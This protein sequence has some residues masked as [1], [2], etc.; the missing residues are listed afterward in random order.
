VSV[1]EGLSPPYAT[2]VADPPWPVEL[3]YGKRKGCP[4]PTRATYSTMPV[5]AICA[6]PVTELAA[7]DAH[8]YLWVTPALNRRGVGIRVARAWGFRVVSELVWSKARL[9]TGAF[10]RA[11]HEILLICRRGARP[12]TAPRNVRS[13]QDWPHPRGHSVKPA[14]AFDLI[15]QASP[16]PYVELFCR[17]PRFGW[18]HWG[19]GYE[20]A[21]P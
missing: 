5:E 15:E 2:I 18:D 10:P 11:C 7:A 13:V 6:L 16:G 4:L 21:V 9:G 14:A 12:F 17:Q 3:D 19:H 1:W 8:L 20:A